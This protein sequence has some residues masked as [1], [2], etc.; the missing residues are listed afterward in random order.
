MDDNAAATQGLRVGAIKVVGTANDVVVNDTARPR[1][2]DAKLIDSTSAI[3]IAI[4]CGEPEV[5]AACSVD[6]AR[7]F[8][9]RLRAGDDEP[10]VIGAMEV[11]VTSLELEFRLPRGN[12]CSV[13]ILG[14]E[15]IV[16]FAGRV[17]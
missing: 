13:L 6:C 16:R 5:V 11:Q 14:D 12:S 7:A 2:L 9:L 1:N 10:L 15:S 3:G 17:R 4:R 8:V